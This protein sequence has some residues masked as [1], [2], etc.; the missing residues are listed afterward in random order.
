MSANVAKIAKV[1]RIFLACESTLTNISRITD[2]RRFRTLEKKK[3]NETPKC[4]Q[5]SQKQH[6]FFM[7]AKTPK[8]LK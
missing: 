1:T 8:W 4:P 2:I 6:E 3:P 5:I 7:L